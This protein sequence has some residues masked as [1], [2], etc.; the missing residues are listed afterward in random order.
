MSSEYRPSLGRGQRSSR[1]HR[2]RTR[3]GRRGRG[4]RCPRR[5][6]KSTG[7]C[8][9]RRRVFP[10]R[11]LPSWSRRPVA[12]LQ[13]CPRRHPSRRTTVGRPFVRR[14]P[15]YHGRRCK[16][17]TRRRSDHHRR[18]TASTSRPC[19]GRQRRSRARPGARP[20]HRR[21]R[22]HRRAQRCHPSSAIALGLRDPSRSP[23]RSR[24]PAPG[25]RPRRPSH[26]RRWA[27]SVCDLRGGRCIASPYPNRDPSR[28]D[29]HSDVRT[30]PRLSATALGS[31]RRSVHRAST[32]ALRFDSSLPDRCRDSPP[33]RSCPRWRL[34]HEGTVVGRRTRLYAP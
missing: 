5:V 11:F 21:S 22:V 32:C 9:R 34:R 31:H 13:R 30:L 6:A 24:R 7:Q 18:D 14:G 28:R 16:Q 12:R 23:L 29:A 1:R 25:R 2:P 3:G 4:K 27:G 26:Q 10:P 17:S 20:S 33:M 19:R 15:E 8:R